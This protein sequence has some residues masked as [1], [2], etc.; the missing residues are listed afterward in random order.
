MSMSS[1]G[2]P[3]EGGRMFLV[4]P[5]SR[6]VNVGP[7]S[8]PM[9]LWRCLFLKGESWARTAEVFRKVAV[10]VCGKKTTI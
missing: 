4:M 7:T 5:T 9:R 6:D 2:G 8:A 3:N 10:G 1:S